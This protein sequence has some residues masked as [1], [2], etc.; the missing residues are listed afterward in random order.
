LVDIF[1]CFIF[2]TGIVQLS[3][4]HLWTL[5]PGKLA[6]AAHIIIAASVDYDSVLETLRD[7]LKKH[8]LYHMTLQLDVRTQKRIL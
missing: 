5:T 6:L 4:I 1:S 3:K 7:R 2:F 8:R